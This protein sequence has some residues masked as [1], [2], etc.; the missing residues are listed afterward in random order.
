MDQKRGIVTGASRGLGRSTA[1]ALA[2]AGAL[3]LAAARDQDALLE[4]CELAS[5]L[6]GKIIGVVADVTS[7]AE[8]KALVDRCVSEFGGLDY[9]VNNAGVQVERSL[10]DTT[11]EDW[12]LVDVTNV[13]ATFWSCKYAIAWM[14][15]N[16]GGSIVNIASVLSV[17]ADPMLPAYTASKHAVLGLT[18]S[19]AVTREYARAGVRANAVLPG[20]METPM[21]AQY[22]ASHDDPDAA[23]QQIA[24]AY[25]AERISDP[26]EVARVVR[27]LVS[28]ESSFVNGSAITVDGGILASLYTTA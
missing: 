14:I 6:P 2:E 12:D 4:T 17:S 5:D 16:G 21:V 15:A 7:E 1:L 10:L 28:D 13:R 20:D 24:S 26:M 3:I 25:P 11:N 18:R 19:I 9:V 22:F 27:F 23:R 8:V